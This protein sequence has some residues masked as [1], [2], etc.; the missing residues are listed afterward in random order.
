MIGTPELKAMAMGRIGN[1]NPLFRWIS[2]QMKLHSA[3]RCTVL[4][5]EALSSMVLA[6]QRF[7]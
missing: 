2:G 7:G 6:V 3:Y 4:L 5:M 1:A